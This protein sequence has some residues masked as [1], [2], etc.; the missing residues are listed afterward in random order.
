MRVHWWPGP[1][2]LP[3]PHPQGDG[4]VYSPYLL[5]RTWQLLQQETHGSQRCRIETP[6]D[7]QRLINFVYGQR[8]PE[9]DDTVLAQ[10]LTHT[11]QRWRDDLSNELNTAQQYGIAPYLPDGTPIGVAEL[12]SRP[13]PD[14]EDDPFQRN[15]TARS[16]LGSLSCPVTCLFQQPGQEPTWDIEGRLPADRAALPERAPATIAQRRRRERDLMLN[17]AQLPAWWF[18]GQNALP[19]PAPGHLLGYPALVGRPTLIFDTD[20]NCVQGCPGRIVFDRETG[21]ALT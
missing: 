5:A 8:P 14:P 21:F 2:G 16:R 17:T 19:R 3:S 4:N 15:P 6:R 20:G 11:Y 7:S 12:A 18:T 1:G 9:A 10:L 13:V